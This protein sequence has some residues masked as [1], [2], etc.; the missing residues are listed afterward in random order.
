MIP[1][2]DNEPTPTATPPGERPRFFS[3]SEGRVLIIGLISLAAAIGVF[4][5]VKCCKDEWADAVQ[6]H[7]SAHI[8]GGRAL[9]MIAGRKLGES[10]PVAILISSVIDL[11]VVFN[12]F[13]LIVYSY[14][15][16]VEFRLFGGAMKAAMDAAHRQRHRVGKWG[17]VGIMLF[18]WF[19][20]AMTG[21]LVGSLI[22]FLIGL[23]V[24]VD[25]AVV[26]VGT[27]LAAISWAFFYDGMERALEGFH[28]LA[29]CVLIC[30]F[31]VLLVFLRVRSLSK[32]RNG[33]S[34]DRSGQ[35]GEERTATELDSNGMGKKG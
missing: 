17:V 14:K 21:P 7:I 6:A 30:V 27:I 24:W 23:R 13:P 1:N 8:L 33:K 11:L 29:P 19:P 18:V 35:V 4:V 12:L 25:M 22:G 5:L 9:G 10:A 31:L 3:T 32:R 34:G 20:F 26:M 16:L 28:S 15:H 2:G